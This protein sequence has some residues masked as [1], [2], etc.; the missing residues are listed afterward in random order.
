M[1]LFKKISIL[2]TT[3]FLVFYSNTGVFASFIWESSWLD[4][5]KTIDKW[6]NSYQSKLIEK[7]LNWS[8]ESVN[9]YLTSRNSPILNN[10][11]DFTRS[12][13]EMISGSWWVVPIIKR[14]DDKQLETFDT[15]QVIKMANLVKERY[16]TKKSEIS[17]DIDNA[18]KISVVWLYNDWD[19]AN[20]WY[21]IID[22]INK[23]HSIIFIDNPKYDWM[24][25]TAAWD[26]NNALTAWFWDTSL[27][28]NL[29][30]ILNS[31][32][33][34]NWA[35]S[36]INSTGDSWNNKNNSN[37][38]NTGLSLKWIDDN[39]LNDL[40]RQIKLWDNSNSN[41][42]WKWNGRSPFNSG[43]L[44]LSNENWALF[45]VWGSKT[46]WPC[47]WFICIKIEMTSYTQ[48]LLGWWARTIE[49][50]VEKHFKIVNSTA[51]K[52]NVQ[53]DISLNFF[54]LSILRNLNLPSM[55]HLW[56]VVSHLPPP[57]LNLSKS[58][59]ANWAGWS[60]GSKW[61]WSCAD[62]KNSAILS[63]AMKQNGI[64]SNRPNYI[65]PDYETKDMSNTEWLNTN[66]ANQKVA[67]TNQFTMP[68][69]KETDIMIANLKNNCIW[70]WTNDDVSELIGFSNSFK[71]DVEVLL[72]YVDYMNKKK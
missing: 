59:W 36:A 26:F 1:K 48:W 45:W 21:D 52:P 64:D 70:W 51:N 4:F 61:I 25:N 22:D 44:N 41:N 56:L 12:E 42:W 50:I 20:S 15:N 35:N 39:L 72:G 23:I 18:A 53:S 24:K 14:L 6:Y 69:I 33:N 34:N 3:V 28:L 49:W 38:C 19:T 8:A 32:A 68:D 58:K 66:T 7:S 13:L 16:E 57:I 9:M 62:L 5:F 37:L 27:A 31:W 17:D 10:K 67:N 55:A 65:S 2:L 54:W 40:D 46:G 43:N 30:G 60:V 11:I 71:A 63:S 47:L 29:S